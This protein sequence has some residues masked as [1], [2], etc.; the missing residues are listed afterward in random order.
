MRD[1]EG[2]NVASRLPDTEKEYKKHNG[3]ERLINGQVYRSACVC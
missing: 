1:I 2:D 3:K